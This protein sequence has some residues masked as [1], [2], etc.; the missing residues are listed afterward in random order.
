MIQ[1]FSHAQSVNGVLELPGDK[2]IS[3]RSVMFSAMAEGTSSIRH[4]SSAEDVMSTISCFRSLGICIEMKGDELIVKGSGFKGF[5]EPSEPV[6]CGNSGTTAR[7]IS[8]ILC[9]QDFS[10]TLTGDASLS[11][12]P[13]K[14][15]AAPLSEMGAVLRPTVAG[16][17]PMLIEPTGQLRAVDYKMQVG[18][19]QIKSALIFAAMHIDEQT[20]IYEKLCTRDHS[21]RMLGLEVNGSENGN[22]ISVS[23]KNYP[24]AQDY[25]IPADI[26]TAA[27]FIVLTLLVPGSEL[28]IKNVS[29]NP[30]RTGILQV[31]ASMGADISVLEEK[32]SCNEPY[33]DVLVRSGDLKNTSIP[34]SVIP[35]IIDEIPVLSVAGLFAEGEFSIS[36]AEEL[37]VKESDRIAALCHNYR[38]LGLDVDERPDGF[39]ISGEIRN[40]GVVFDSFD[41]HR[42]AMAFAILSMISRDGGSVRDF[43][44]VAI[45]NPRFLSQSG[46]ITGIRQ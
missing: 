30:T 14:R 31:L 9:A 6:Y 24:V 3:H 12:R 35:N 13:M 37:R 40:R 22:V 7:L 20:R 8:G 2:S 16:T 38:L 33:G 36:G 25:F 45:S 4:L 1:K 15:V 18:S 17:L 23:R 5:R 44:C 41:D 28:M 39:S 10:V 27:F 42:I 43:E 11:K 29:L 34:E 21:E 26:S 32:Y 19:A 46:S